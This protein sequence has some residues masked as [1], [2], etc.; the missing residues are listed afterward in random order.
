MTKVYEAQRQML[1]LEGIYYE[2]AGATALAGAAK[3]LAKGWI[4]PDDPVVCIVTGHGFK[5]FDSIA[6][7]AALHPERRVEARDLRDILLREVA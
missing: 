3:A 5:N 2:P 7:A 1:A 4:A 6:G